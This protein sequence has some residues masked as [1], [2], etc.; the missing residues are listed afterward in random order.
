MT[1]A[2]ITKTLKQWELGGLC[3][4]L[5]VCFIFYMFVFKDCI[6]I[7]AKL[8]VSFKMYFSLSKKKTCREVADY[9]EGD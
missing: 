8:H 9:I 6:F 1:N 5:F 7:K 4:F 2:V 3:V